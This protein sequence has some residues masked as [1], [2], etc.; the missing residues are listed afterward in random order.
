VTPAKTESARP[1]TAGVLAI[2][3]TVVIS[4]YLA[5]R[6][7]TPSTATTPVLPA[8]SA[9]AGDGTPRESRASGR[10]VTPER[11][12]AS[13][14]AVVEYSD[15]AGLEALQIEV[16]AS[17]D[18]IA[19]FHG[20]GEVAH[21][22]VDGHTHSL[23]R[24]RIHR[25][26]WRWPLATDGGT[27][28]LV[29]HLVLD[30]R[31]ALPIEGLLVRGSGPPPLLRAIWAAPVS[32]EVLD[33]ESLEPIDD[34]E[35]RYDTTPSEPSRQ[36]LTEL[37][38][39]RSGGEGGGLLEVFQEG[40]GPLRRR[41]PEDCLALAQSSASPVDV[42]RVSDMGTYWITASGYCWR[43]WPEPEDRD[44]SSPRVLLPRAADLTVSADCSRYSDSG[45]LFVRVYPSDSTRRQP[46]FEFEQKDEVERFVFD[47]LE[48]RPWSITLESEIEL[49]GERTVDV[50]VAETVALDAG[51]VSIALACPNG[52][53]SELADVVGSCIVECLLPDAVALGALRAERLG[54]PLTRI[55]GLSRNPVDDSSW[56]FGPTRLLPGRWVFSLDEL[57]VQGAFRIEPGM[58]ALVLPA[59]D[60]RWRTIELVERGSGRPVACTRIGWNL[61]VGDE[62]A[63]EVLPT[64]LRR[65]RTRRVDPSEQGALVDLQ[66]PQGRILFNGQTERHGPF[67]T[68][69]EVGAGADRITFEVDSRAAATLRVELD[70]RPVTCT[71]DWFRRI[72]LRSDAGEEVP[73]ELT[74]RMSPGRPPSVTL[75]L[76]HEGWIELSSPRSPLTPRL[77]PVQAFVSRGELTEIVFTALE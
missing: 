69:V 15:S 4:V 51:P 8:G 74:Y 13:Q 24:S 71:P 60:Y 57:P 66:L 2:V 37:R 33:A 10:Q 48:R 65:F 72:E 75:W 21:R 49:N 45:R 42:E 29:D 64:V 25:G 47:K 28:I 3:A 50:L 26:A 14:R 61:T 59:L 44:R 20:D 18:E 46:A 63:L 36:A 76:E 70:G 38:L 67:H 22:L 6:S 11:A 17:A 68:S 52:S 23:A 54:A 53:D 56:T 1:S 41:P 40:R 73:F 16:G 43:R 58:N 5:T 62:D 34:V 55:I 30:G 39:H 35:I 31:R 19:P 77:A 12:E 9:D 7:S 32:F 27:A